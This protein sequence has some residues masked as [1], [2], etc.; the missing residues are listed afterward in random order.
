MSNMLTDGL[1]VV[2]ISLKK[3]LYFPDTTVYPIS[4]KEACFRSR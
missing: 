3:L 1:G 4:G 2:Y